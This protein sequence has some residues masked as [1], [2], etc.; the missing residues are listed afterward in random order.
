MQAAPANGRITGAAGI[1]QYLN[2]FSRDK[3]EVI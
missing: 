1:F 3:P 2:E